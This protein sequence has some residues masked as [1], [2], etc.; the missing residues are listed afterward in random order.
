[1]T[2]K[3]EILPNEIFLNIF[4]Y[5]SWDEILISFWSLNK[6]INSIICSIF[7]INK[8]GIIFNKPGLS[9]K[10]FSKILLPLIF[11]S[12]SLCSSI[13]YIH[14]DGI[15]SI[16]FNLIYQDIFSHNDKS[17]HRFPNLKSLYITRCLL[18]QSLI[19]TLSFLIQYQ[20]NQLTLT[21][22]EDIY[23]TFS[24]GYKLSSIRSKHGN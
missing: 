21:F 18:S 20:L 22:H 17:I 10:K 23:E 13:K 16:G 4:L 3:L 14:I 1:M 9:Y 6:R 7:E 15:N 19:Q 2:N 12:L 8:N 24:S 11:N 5:F